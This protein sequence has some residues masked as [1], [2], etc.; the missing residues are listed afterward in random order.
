M[1]ARFTAFESPLERHLEG[2]RAYEEHA[3]E[4]MRGATG[5]R[6][7]LAL[8]DR[9]TG[10]SIFL[11]F[12]SDAEAE[13]AS[14]EASDRFRELAAATVG[15]TLLQGPDRYEVVLTEGIRLEGPEPR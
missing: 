9:A 5:F 1:I 6:G 11:T 2:V 7:M 8:A 3:L 13:A 4:W 10:K 14:Q 12:W 15:S